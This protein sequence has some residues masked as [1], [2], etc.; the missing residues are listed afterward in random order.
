ML[1]GHGLRG[2]YLGHEVVGAS[3]KYISQI[4]TLLPEVREK[5]TGLA[6]QGKTPLCFAKDGKLIGIIAVVC[7][8]ADKQK[9]DASEDNGDDDAYS[10]H[11]VISQEVPSVFD[12]FHSKHNADK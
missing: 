5:A 9:N 11:I 3:L 4:T 8:H 6:S 1:P 12:A 7:E 10:S 2:K